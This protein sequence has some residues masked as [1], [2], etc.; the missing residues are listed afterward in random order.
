MTRVPR[1]LALLIASCL[2]IAGA[3]S[4]MAA[5]R[6]V[7][8]AADAARPNATGSGHYVSCAHEQ[9]S[10]ARTACIGRVAAR[11][12]TS[13]GHRRAIAEIERAARADAGIAVDCH[14]ALHPTGAAEG[15]RLAR[16]HAPLPLTKPRSFCDEGFV[17]GEQIAWFSAASTIELR[18]TGIRACSSASSINDWACGHSFGHVLAQRTGEDGT[19]ATALDWCQEAYGRAVHLGLDRDSWLTTC[20][21]GAMMEFSFADGRLHRSPPRA[22]CAGVRSELVTWCDAHVWLRTR[23]TGGTASLHAAQLRACAEWTRTREGSRA[24]RTI[25][26]DSSATRATDPASLPAQ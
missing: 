21:R 14:M 6:T 2:L 18:A 13:V 26:E 20:A 1:H 24:C 5:T 11:R 22:P 12:V 7:G 4:A 8:D 9:Q 19:M 16:A 15:A 25:V 17:H 23:P 10:E 3:A